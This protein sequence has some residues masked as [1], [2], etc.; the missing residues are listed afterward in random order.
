MNKKQYFRIAIVYKKHWTED[1]TFYAHN[2]WALR[3]ITHFFSMPE[4]A[5]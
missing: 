1:A 4:E 3:T 5:R 2:D